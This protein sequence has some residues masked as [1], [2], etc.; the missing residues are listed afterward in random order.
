MAT[1]ESLRQ[2]SGKSFRTLYLMPGIVLGLLGGVI[3]AS[4]CVAS[5]KYEG[6]VDFSTRCSK[7]QVI[8]C[9]GFDVEDEVDP[10]VYPP[11]GK[12][13]KLA[14]VD[15]KV[16]ASGEGSL[17]FTI[18]SHSGNDTSGKFMMNFADD[19]SIQFGEGEEFY[20]QWRQR[21]SES[22]LDTYYDRGYGWKQV[23]VSEGDRPGF[24]S[25][26]CNQLQLV[27]NNR[28]QRGIPHVYHNCGKFEDLGG[29]K[30]Y[31][32]DEWMTFQLHV[33]IGTWYKKDGN[34]HEDSTVQFWVAREGEASELVINLSPDPSRVFGANLIGGGSG[35]DLVN[36]NP[37]AKY[38][39]IHLTPYHTRKSPQQDHP[40]GYTWYDELIISKAKISDP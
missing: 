31:Y 24:Q 14:I 20:I 27:V 15:K 5:S 21:F 13:E 40:V 8:R 18:P 32:A 23:I 7:P 28:S 2:K 30:G 35:Y 4:G 38:G 6:G 12:V 17:R 16:K 37:Q 25:P 19:F 39:K 36:T 10:Y 1:G 33:K 26:G 11:W 34:Y 22:F 9:V 3:G 29:G